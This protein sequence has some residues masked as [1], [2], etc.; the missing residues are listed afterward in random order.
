[1]RIDDRLRR[2]PVFS[3]EFGPP[4]TPEAELALWTAVEELRALD[5]AFVSVTWGAGGSTR[6]PTLETVRRMHELHGLEAMPHLTCIGSTRAE[7][8]ALIDGIA[9]DGIENLL[10][11]RGDG[12]DIRDISTAAEL[13]RLAAEAGLCVVGACYPESDELDYVRAKVDAG[14]TVLITQ[15]FFDNAHYF[16][17]VDRLRRAGIDVP[18]LPGVIPIT[19]AGQ[20]ARMV[21]LCGASI[22]RALERELG[23]RA[24]DP[25]AVADFGVAYATAQCFELLAGGAPG[26]HLF[27]LNRSPATRAIVSALRA[28]RSS[29]RI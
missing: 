22:P 12:D 24:D 9:E 25:R 23:L 10:A 3:F 16:R 17:F 8:R 7:L 20:L 27:T 2:G 13:A 5:P 6:G 18:V 29:V 14:V 28:G 26:V 11:L 1:M 4:R 19:H 21:S 15:L